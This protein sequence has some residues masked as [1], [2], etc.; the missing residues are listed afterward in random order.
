M[1]KIKAKTSMRVKVK[2]DFMSPLT[3][4]MAKVD[5]E[6]NVPKTMFWLRRIKDGDCEQMKLGKRK[7]SAPKKA[8]DAKD[9]KKGSN[10]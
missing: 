3:N 5:Q 6:M 10:E 1:E 2:K 4:R 8:Q 9:S 7:K